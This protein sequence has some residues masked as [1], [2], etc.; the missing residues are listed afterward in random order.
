[1]RIL[2][3]DD[4]PIILD[5]LKFLMVQIGGHRLITVSGAKEALEEVSK[6]GQPPFDCFLLDID[7]PGMNGIELCELLRKHSLY[8]NCPILMITNMDQRKFVYEAFAAGATDYLTKPIE[9]NEIRTRIDRVSN[10]SDHDKS[11]LH[12]ILVANRDR[13]GLAV[14]K[15]DAI[16]LL[17]TASI[18]GL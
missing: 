7:M 3:V 5:L 16:N 15:P 9:L 2:A 17:D 18:S 10:L 6:P 8:Q 13:A 12:G 4:D 11:A 1:M 14:Q